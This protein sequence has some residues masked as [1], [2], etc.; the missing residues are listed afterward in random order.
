MK[1]MDKPLSAR[2]PL[3]AAL[4]ADFSSV[5]HL[6]Q[7]DASKPAN[8]QERLEWLDHNEDN[9]INRQNVVNVLRSYNKLHNS[10]PQVCDSLD[11]LEQ[12][13]TAVIVGGQQSGLFTGPLLVIYKA[14]TVI[15]AARKAEAELGRPVVP[16]FWIAG[17]D[18]DWDEANHT[19]VLSTELKVTRIRM[20]R[21]D[22]LRTP[23]SY[24]TV[25]AG[26]WDRVLDELNELLPDT[27][28]KPQ[29]MADL[30]ESV[31][32]TLSLSFA[33]LLGKLFGQYGLILLDSADHELRKLEKDMFASII[34]EGDA[35]T[36]SYI[37]AARQIREM[38]LEEQAEVAE[39]GANLFYLQDQKRLLLFR[40]G[41]R[42]QDRSGRVSFT[43]E[44]L[45]E[46]IEQHPE[47]FSNN[48]LTRPLMQDTLLPVLG[49]VLG[50]GE[51]AYWALLKKAFGVMN[52]QMPLLLPRMSLTVVEGTL[53]KYM[54]Q[55]GL[56][57]EEVRDHF[58]DRKAAWL[59]QQDNVHVDERFDEVKE[60]FTRLY[61][62][63]IEQLGTIEKGL[64]RLGGANKERIL[65]QMDFLQGKAKDALAT[66]NEATLRHWDRIYLSLMPQDKLQE[67]VY[68]I[69]Y[70]LNRYGT[71]FMDQLME[72]P[73]E[74]NACHKLI[75]L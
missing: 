56:T 55:Y 3:A 58:Q 47:R 26:E 44:E 20:Y 60:A 64:I 69:F 54:D 29:L 52:L 59:N 38:G 31:S 24:T 19:Y 63:L 17:E 2:Q 49:F 42:Y 62:P 15:Q 46:Q 39:D 35:L 28:F 74:T 45:L 14:A 8:W 40:S 23:V 5:A 53:Q 34:R 61:E 33:K 72:I 4:T 71:E 27:E 11:R 6:Y 25:Q 1:I 57:F 10:H 75:L 50:D 66:A 22:D 36:A 12:K 41:D 65:A 21:E 73:Y 32:E 43:R 16:V 37:D 13:G 18:H 67:R 48:V 68:N 70:Y 7:S 30:R 9:R 51:I